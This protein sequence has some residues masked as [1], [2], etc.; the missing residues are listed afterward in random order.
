V[1]GGT[2]LGRTACWAAA[3][4]ARESGREDRLLD[5]PWAAA[6]AGEEGSAWLADHGEDTTIV[7]AIRAR[8]F[9]DFLRRHAPGV[10]Q[11]ILLA[12]GLDTRSFRL[13]WPENTTV[14]EL[15]QPEVLDRKERVLVGV[16]PV[17]S[18]HVVGVDLTGDWTG[19]LVDIGFDVSMPSLWLLE[20]FLFYLTPTD[21]DRM[22]DRVTDLAAVGSRMGFDII[23]GAMLTSSWT[24]AWVA[25]QEASGAPWIGTL[26]DPA[27]FLA[28][29]GWQAALTQAGE[30][31]ADYGRWRLPI[32]P[33]LAPDLPHDWFV[34]AR[35]TS[36]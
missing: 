31:D 15:D 32:L 30:A 29:R 18:R 9:D 24:R 3:V 2:D 36:R 21:I 34:T 1:A 28:D 17:C 25:M 26:D 8:F 11:V 7:M 12:A 5:D 23:N 4:R 6:L 35:R 13:S 22:I 33:V 20:G 19:R 10:H 16:K 14:F 27:Q